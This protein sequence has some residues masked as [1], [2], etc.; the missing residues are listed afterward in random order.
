MMTV[1]C[2][3]RNASTSGFVISPRNTVGGFMS[4]SDA[5][6]YR[7]AA[8]TTNDED[9]NTAPSCL[10]LFVVRSLLHRQTQDRA[11]AAVRRAVLERQ[12]AAVGL[13]DLT[14]ERQAD[15]GAGRLGGEERDEQVRRVGQPGPFVLDADLDH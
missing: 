8:G 10:R 11:A 2:V 15:A 4:R 13:G 5:Q 9:A 1:P 14:A 7:S 12:R 3:F 6:V